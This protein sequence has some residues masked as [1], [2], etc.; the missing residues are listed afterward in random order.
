MQLRKKE[1]MN[2]RAFFVLS[3]SLLGALALAGCTDEAYGDEPQ[4]AIYAQA[5]STPAP[6]TPAA[7]PNLT[8]AASGLGEIIVN[9]KG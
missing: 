5:S 1:Y 3:A 4:S 6:S 7:A 8:T 9:G 2:K